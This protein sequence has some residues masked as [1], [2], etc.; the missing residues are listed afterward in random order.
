MSSWA[1]RSWIN[2]GFAQPLGQVDVPGERLP[3]LPGLAQP[4]SFPASSSP[5]GLPTA[6]PGPAASF[7]ISARAASSRR[8]RPGGGGVHGGE[9]PAVGFGAPT[10]QR[11]ESRS[12]ATVT[13]AVHAHRLG[14]V[15]RGGDVHRR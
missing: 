9:N 10:T 4:S 12:S 11:A 3:L 14:P 6:P 1:S 15:H 5:A 2:D 7:S 8:V 13:R